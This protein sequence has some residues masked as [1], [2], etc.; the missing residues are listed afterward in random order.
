MKLRIDDLLVRNGQVVELQK[1]VE[2]HKLLRKDDKELA[3]AR[4]QELVIE[5][6]MLKKMLKKVGGYGDVLLGDYIFGRWSFG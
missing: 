2:K 3:E 1:K 5:I 6:E 4:I